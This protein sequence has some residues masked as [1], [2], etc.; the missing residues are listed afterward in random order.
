[1]DIYEKYGIHI[2]DGRRYY[3]C[4]VSD[5]LPILENTIPYYFSYKDIEIHDN[6]WGH[7]ATTILTELDKRNPKSDDYLLGLRYDWSKADVF[8]KSKRTN[9]TPFRDIYLNTNHTSTHALMSIQ[10]LLRAYDVDLKECY[11]LINRHPVVEPP[12]VRDYIIN[13]ETRR[14][15][16]YLLAQGFDFIRVS[17]MLTNFETINKLL[18][19]TPTSFDNF[20]LFDDY[21]YFTSYRYKV[22]KE[23]EE[24]YLEKPKNIELIKKYLTYYDDYMKK[25]DFYEKYDSKA[26]LPEFQEQILKELE[27]LFASLKSEVITIS[28]IYSRLKALYP[29]QMNEIEF[30]NTQKGLFEY[31]KI[32]YG[33]N[34][35]F[36]DPYIS[37][38]PS[39]NLT[40]NDIIMNYAYSLDE[41]DVPKLV[42]YADKMHI[43][44][45]TNYLAFIINCS[46]DY[47]LIRPGTMK[48]KELLNIGEGYL[49]ELSSSISYYINSYGSID[50]RTYSGYPSLPKSSSNMTMDKYLLFG[51]VLSYLSDKFDVECL[52]GTYTDFQ[53]IIKAKQ[54]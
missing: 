35:Y 27:Y 52:G 53:Y 38:T 9:F 44:R 30:L 42:E 14:F 49:S 50:S 47:V 20:Y 25:K 4:D 8:S 18:A 33:K 32:K 29:E 13:L 40:V 3:E 43:N 22:I 21:M 37:K 31:L 48:K 15:S 51:L 24:K 36:Q 19:S 17:K 23:A 54:Q 39:D 41:F 12:E 16:K 34:Y 1:M 45:I 28:K 6:K 10:C 26:V 7:L 2:I 46:E 11:L 5:K